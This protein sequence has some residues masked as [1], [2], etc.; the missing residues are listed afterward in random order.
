[1][2]IAGCAKQQMSSDSVSRGIR[3]PPA[4]AGPAPRG[5]R[6]APPA[7][8]R[9][10]ASPPRPLHLLLF[11]LFL[12]YLHSRFCCRRLMLLLLLSKRLLHFHLAIRPC[13]CG[14]H[15][16]LRWGCCRQ[17]GD[18]YVTTSKKKRKRRMRASMRACEVHVPPASH[19]RRQRLTVGDQRP[20]P[21][22]L[23]AAAPPPLLGVPR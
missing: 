4:G 8:G 20:P 5:P 21:A 12:S 2:R 23:L 16:L 9:L 15:L 18:V 3:C 1:M 14:R 13:S 19:R 17:N 7:A 6:C 11:L 10:Q 22:P